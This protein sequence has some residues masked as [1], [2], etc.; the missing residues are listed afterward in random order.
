MNFTESKFFA[1]ALMAIVLALVVFLFGNT[2]MDKIADKVIERISKPYSPSP[3]G[4]GFDPD[5]LDGYRGT[6]YEGI[7]VEKD[8]NK[9]ENEWEYSRDN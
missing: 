3:F 1:P 6:S 8:G 4:A 2:V 7:A 5:K 9:W